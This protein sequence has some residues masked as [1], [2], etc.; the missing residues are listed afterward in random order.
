MPKALKR[1]LV[2]HIRMKVGF[3]AYAY[4]PG[5]KDD[6]GKYEGPLWVTHNPPSERIKMN[7]DHIRVFLDD[8]EYVT[9][10]PRKE[11]SVETNFRIGK[12]DWISILPP[13]RLLTF[14]EAMRVL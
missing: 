7:K 6:E 3:R 5:R 14:K 11:W 9:A 10:T 13:D 12:L 4:I 2:R 1:G 8:G